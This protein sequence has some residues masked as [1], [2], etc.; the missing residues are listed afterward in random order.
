M[1]VNHFDIVSAATYSMKMASS[2]VAHYL[3]IIGRCSIQTILSLIA[4]T[5]LR[6]MAVLTVSLLHAKVVVYRFIINDIHMLIK[7]VHL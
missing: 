5:F 2:M 1:V 3:E 4:G 6:P 7:Y